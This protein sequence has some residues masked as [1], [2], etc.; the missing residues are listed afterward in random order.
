MRRCALRLAKMAATEVITISSSPRTELVHHLSSPPGY[1]L[2][3]SPLE[4]PNKIPALRA[5]SKTAP[6]PSGGQE[7]FQPVSLLSRFGCS[8]FGIESPKSG[9]EANRGK[10][11]ALVKVSNDGTAEEENGTKKKRRRKKDPSKLRLDRKPQSSKSKGTKQKPETGPDHDKAGVGNES[12]LQQTDN[13][14]GG[15]RSH[16]THLSRLRIDEGPPREKNSTLQESLRDKTT[17][18][19]VD[20]CKK[21]KVSTKQTRINGKI[22]KPGSLKK[23][24]KAVFKIPLGCELPSALPEVA[25]VGRNSAGRIEETL[26]AGN[27]TSAEPRELQR[28]LLETEGSQKQALNEPPSELAAVSVGSAKPKPLS[29]AELFAN[30]KGE[31]TYQ[32]QSTS[33]SNENAERRHPVTEPVGKRKC[34]EVRSKLA[35][36]HHSR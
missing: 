3:K 12:L 15:T 21:P 25:D 5:G 35:C 27:G 6:I 22:T 20:G 13:E 9:A 4:Q 18:V 36:K 26:P 7:G 8:D 24:E 17:E 32:I 11:K 1:A 19:Y 33:V 31:F 29:K 30:L 10:R 2:L 14:N 23:T 28:T 16:S 34:F